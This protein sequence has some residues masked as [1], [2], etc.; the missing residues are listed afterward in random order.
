VE[1][2]SQTIK[3]IVDKEKKLTQQAINVRAIDSKAPF[4]F[5]GM[6][7]ILPHDRPQTSDISSDE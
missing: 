5:Q 4:Q 6:Q 1:Y 2:R 3:K 7:L